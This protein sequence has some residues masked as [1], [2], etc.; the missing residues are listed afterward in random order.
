MLAK[1]KAAGETPIIG[2][3]QEAWPGLHFWGSVQGEF[4]DAQTFAT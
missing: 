1:A 2:G 3:N 4:V